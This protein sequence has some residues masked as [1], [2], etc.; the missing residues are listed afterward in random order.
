MEDHVWMDHATNTDNR[1]EYFDG[2]TLP[3]TREGVELGLEYRND[4][5]IACNTSYSTISV[6]I[7]VYKYS[8]YVLNFA[9]GT[10]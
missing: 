1:F 9:K 8:S 4:F 2:S 10:R 7:D 5:G 6:T 3:I